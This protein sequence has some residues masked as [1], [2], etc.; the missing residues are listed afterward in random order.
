MGTCGSQRRSRLTT[1]HARM[2]KVL[3]RPPR[4]AL[5]CGVVANT[6]RKGQAHRCWVHGTCTTTAT[7]IQRH[8]GLL[9][10]RS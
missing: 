9:T 4:H 10:D 1:W 2:P 5:T 6:H 8:P 7:T 3:C